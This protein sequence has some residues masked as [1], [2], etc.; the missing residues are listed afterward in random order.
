[1]NIVHVVPNIDLDSGGPSYSVTRLCE[2]L[3][4]LTPQVRLL[5][6]TTGL[7]VVNCAAPV[8]AFPILGSRRLAFSPKLKAGLKSAGLAHSDI[9]HSHGLWMLPNIY[10]GAV[11]RQS[12]CQL[13]LSPRGMLASWSLQR[14]RF[15]KRIS[16]W[17]GQSEML[18]QVDCFHATAESEYED[19]RRLGFRQ[20]VTVI[21]N[22]VDMPAESEHWKK[23]KQV[24]FLS[25]IHP[26]KGIETLLNAWSRIQDVASDW[27][28]IICGPGE[29]DYLNH[30]EQQI[31]QTQGRVCSAPPVFG[32][33]KSQLFHQSSL[34]VLPT[35]SENFGIVVAEALAHQVPAI[36]T[37]GAPWQGLE[38]NGCGWWIEDSVTSL[39][40]SLR[41]GMS[42]SKDKLAAM[43]RS[44]R[45][46]MLREFSWGGVADQMLQTYLWLQGQGDVPAFVRKD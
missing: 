10:P 42:L 32:Q 31:A 45:Q 35:K 20:P 4:A 28:L 2:E 38:L 39:E 37:Q 7:S 30:I 12:A 36:V 19:I 22:G 44:G 11:R 21:P 25:R 29:S 13:V 16:S 3:H 18:A 26:K 34:F 14:S 40:H 46:W 24:L 43:G 1:M 23:Q 9:L 17:L 8:Q 41:Q 6:T 27:Q 33:D 5:T 15:K